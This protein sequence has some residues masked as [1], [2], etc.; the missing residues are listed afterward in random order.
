MKTPLGRLCVIVL[1]VFG[2]MSPALAQ[3]QTPTVSPVLSGADL[4][5]R[6]S[7]ERADFSLPSG[8]QSYVSAIYQGKWLLLAG[9]TN[10]LHD[11]NNDDNNFPPR[12]QN[13]TV[14]ATSRRPTAST[15][16]RCVGSASTMTG[17]PCRSLRKG[18]TRSRRPFRPTPAIGGET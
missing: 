2:S 10:G 18:S 7:I 17:S 6:V 11:F 3:N 5:F 9:R 1:G 15:A 8:L 13:T 4:P 12:K 14:Y 16:S